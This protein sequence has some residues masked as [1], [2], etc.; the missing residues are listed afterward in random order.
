MSN[1]SLQEL[2]GHLLR[3][4]GY[5]HFLVL[6]ASFQ[7]PARL[8]WKEDLEQLMPLNRKLLWVQSTF[9]VL[10]IIAFG[11]LTLL[12]HGEM[13][14]GD[15]SALALVCFIAVYWTTRI[16]VDAFYFTHDDWPSGRKFV[17]GHILLTSLFTTLA[18]TY[19]GL[20]VWQVWL[21]AKIW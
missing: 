16:L 21:R 9:T 13:L 8:R 10:T 1:G 15:R 20:F 6:I 14:R 3:F 2:F 19:W 7:V 11:V 17:F 4:A 18:L 12:L 5:G